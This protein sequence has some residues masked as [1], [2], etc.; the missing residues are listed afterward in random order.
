[1]H[2]F[3]N[4]C[5]GT[6]MHIESRLITREILLLEPAHRILKCIGNEET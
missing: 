1:M 3:G 2:G 6:R 4:D 5:E